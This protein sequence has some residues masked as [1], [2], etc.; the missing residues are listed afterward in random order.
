MFCISF[1]QYS[2][3]VRSISYRHIT[4]VTMSSASIIQNDISWFYPLHCIFYSILFLFYSTP[5]Y[6]QPLHEILQRLPPLAIFPIGLCPS[7]HAA[8]R[9]SRLALPLLPNALDVRA[10]VL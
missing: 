6:F 1:V 4:L 7:H 5:V 3:D 9:T 8:H 2:I 10:P